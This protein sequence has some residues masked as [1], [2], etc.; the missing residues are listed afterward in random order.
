MK[1]LGRKTMQDLTVARNLLKNS[2]HSL[3]IVKAEHVI[4]ETDMHGIR[5]FLEAIEKFG[6]NLAGSS[7]ADKI[8]GEAAAHLCVY[9]RVA[10]VFAATLSK[11]GKDLL[12]KN[13]VYYEYGNLVPHIL[14]IS[15]TDLCP[16]EKRV[17]GS[18]SP[19][20]AYERLKQAASKN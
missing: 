4:F 6:E 8:V 17:E 9:S 20:E 13:N 1:E 10:M 19:K 2:N 12:E 18:R 14:N 11:C 16:F 5:G 7:V 3:V 15:K